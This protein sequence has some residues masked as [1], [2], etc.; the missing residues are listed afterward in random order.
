[1]PRTDYENRAFEAG[2][3]IDVSVIGGPKNQEIFAKVEGGEVRWK[4][5]V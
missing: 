2:I 3:M 5:R 1:M 4:G